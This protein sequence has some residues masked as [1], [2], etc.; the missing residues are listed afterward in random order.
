VVAV[1]NDWEPEGVVEKVGSAVG[2]D[3]HQVKADA[4]R[5]KEFVENRGSHVAIVS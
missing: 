1:L 2:V 4:K 3:S 5:Y